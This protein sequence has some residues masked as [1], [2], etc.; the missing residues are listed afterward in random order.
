MCESCSRNALR[1]W[2]SGDTTVGGSDREQSVMSVQILGCAE[3]NVGKRMVFKNVV[4]RVAN[5]Y[6]G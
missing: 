6:I 5:F 2:G 3:T 1:V 4:L